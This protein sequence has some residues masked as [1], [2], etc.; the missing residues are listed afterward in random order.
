[1]VALGALGVVTH[2]TLA[3]VP[4]YD[5][6][7]TVLENLPLD[8]ALDHLDAVLGSAASVSLF[9][10]W[11]DK[12]IEQ[13]WLK[14]RVGDPVADLA[15]TGAT[16]AD[17]P[18]HPVP[19]ADPVHCTTQ[20]GAVGPWFER[21]PHF[22]LDFTPSSGDELQT[23]Y[24]VARELGVDALRA[25]HAIRDVVAPVL[26]VSEIR[27][28]AADALWLSPAYGRDSL[29]V[30]FTWIADTA[31]VLPAVAAVEAALAP[32]DAR[33]HWGKVFTTEPEALAARY[34]RMD[35]ARRLVAASDPDGVLG[36]A[37][38]DRYLGIGR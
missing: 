20:G 14:H 21:V 28:V 4:A 2:V 32:F 12:G 9:T 25:V 15:W 36:N 8:V 30:H 16:R 10:T 38:V 37:F 19:G 22:R 33:P 23:E 11:R 3:L 18:R 27:S 17:G 13:V 7:Q 24:L 1:V 31:R 29:A 5:V 6:A 26:Q 34:P 35:D